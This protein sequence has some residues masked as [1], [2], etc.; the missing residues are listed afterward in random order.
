MEE[1][2]GDGW[3][4]NVNV[5]NATEPYTWKLLKWQI[6]CVFYHNKKKLFFQRV[7][8]TFREEN[9]ITRLPN[10]N[11]ESL[12]QEKLSLNFTVTEVFMA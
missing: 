11:K 1:S 10:R 2:S 9:S 7:I 4:H 8:D 12:M 5:L 3:W 6:M